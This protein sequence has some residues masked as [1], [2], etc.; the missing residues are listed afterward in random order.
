MADMDWFR[1]A[2][3]AKVPF[4]WVDDVLTNMTEGGVSTKINLKKLSKDR[5]L[6]TNKFYEGAFPKIFMFTKWMFIK[7]KGEMIH[8]LR[9]I[10][11]K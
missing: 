6:Y 11:H 1:R 9:R 3:E 4:L 7:L 8:R 5:W 2:Y 10:F